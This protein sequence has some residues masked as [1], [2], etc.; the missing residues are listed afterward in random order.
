MV[1]SRAGYLV[2]L[3][4][5]V[6]ERGFE[7]WLSAR[8]ARRT[9]DSGWRE[10]GH[11]QYR[12]IIVFHTLFIAVCVAE[13]ILYATPVSPVLS[14]LA[15]VGV[16]F[17]QVLRFWSI[18]TL[19]SSWNA[20]IIVSPQMTIETAGPYRYVRHPNYCAVVLE[21]ACIPLIRGLVMTA[22]LFSIANLILLAFRIPLEERALGE[23]YRRALASRPR[24]FPGLVR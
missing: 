24:F 17:A 11:V 14:L 2:L 13:T 6:M 16:V 22:T 9:L 18:A 23:S 20:R 1:V 8:N 3:T 7:L 10:V 12:I 19:G 15:L 21:I 5:L 4:A